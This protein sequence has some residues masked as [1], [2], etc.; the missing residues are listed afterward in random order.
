MEGG[1]E[2]GAMGFLR[3]PRGRAG[4]GLSYHKLL[5]L[6]HEVSGPCDVPDDPLNDP[7]NDPL[8]AVYISESSCPIPLRPLFHLHQGLFRLRSQ[9]RTIRAT[10]NTAAKGATTSATSVAPAAEAT[11]PAPSWDPEPA[12]GCAVGTAGMVGGEREPRGVQTTTVDWYRERHFKMS[13]GK[14]S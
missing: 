10:T 13:S 4:F 6:D 12:V 8:M 1:K 9:A 3:S 14:W 2:G 7:L 5:I 11:C